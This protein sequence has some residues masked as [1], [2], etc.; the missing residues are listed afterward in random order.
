[1]LPRSSLPLAN[2]LCLAILEVPVLPGSSNFFLWQLARLQYLWSGW[3][4][5]ARGLLRHGSAQSM[6]AETAGPGVL[7]LVLP[8]VS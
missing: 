7:S 2:S 6:G 1:M 5:T 8:T 3:T 4:G